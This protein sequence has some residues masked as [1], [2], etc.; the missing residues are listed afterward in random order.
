M[1]KG[2]VDWDRIHRQIEAVGAAIESGY[3][4]GPEERRRILQQRAEKL[5][6]GR[7]NTAEAD[8]LEVVEFLLAH[9]HYGIESQYIRE[10]CPLRSYAT[11]PGVP[12]FVLGLINVRGQILSVVDIKKFFDIPEKGITDLNKVII[13]GDTTMEFGILADAI[14]GVRDIA[15]SAIGPPLPT[16]TGIR[17]EFLKGVTGE[18]LVVLDAVRILTDG[19]IVVHDEI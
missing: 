11:L 9:E 15:V 7:E 14:I 17:A 19:K 18:R 1:G 5:A 13:I 12:S 4:P 2:K 8:S 3:A 10:V 6:H 16:L